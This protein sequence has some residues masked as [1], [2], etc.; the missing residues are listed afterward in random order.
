MFECG[1]C[2]NQLASS[3]AVRVRHVHYE[4]GW[5]GEFGADDAEIQCEVIDD[6]LWST[7]VDA[8][9]FGQNEAPIEQLKQI[10][11]WLMYCGDDR[12]VFVYVLV[13]EKFSSKTIFC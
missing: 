3:F 2:S 9:A 7:A 4:I 10:R 8:L 5:A 12:S 6:V 13:N 11:V 1:Q